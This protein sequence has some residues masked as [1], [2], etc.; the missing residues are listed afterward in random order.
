MNLDI[1]GY[2]TP[3]ILKPHYGALKTKN[4]FTPCGQNTFGWESRFCRMGG[5]QNL[6]FFIIFHEMKS[7]IPRYEGQLIFMAEPIP[8]PNVP[9]VRP[10]DAHHLSLRTD[11][12]GPT[13]LF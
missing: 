3:L 2:R 9:L 7:V 11:G 5:S 1:S 4:S 8:H 10:H 6:K 13:V 12:Q